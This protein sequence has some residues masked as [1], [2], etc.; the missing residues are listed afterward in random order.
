[1]KTHNL[2][3]NFYPYVRSSKHTSNVSMFIAVVA[4]GTVHLLY[5]DLYFIAPLRRIMD[6]IIL[7]MQKVSCVTRG[8]EFTLFFFAGFDPGLTV[9]RMCS[10]NG[11]HLFDRGSVLTSH[12][13]SS[14]CWAAWR[15]PPGRLHWAPQS[16]GSGCSVVGCRGGLQQVGREDQAGPECCCLAHCPLH[17]LPAAAGSPPASAPAPRKLRQS[18]KMT[19]TQHFEAAVWLKIQF[20]WSSHYLSCS[21]TAKSHLLS[22]VFFFFSCFLSN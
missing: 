1:M 15:V 7:T 13:P 8:S 21:Q 14:C 5:G 9:E 19:L 3:S 20:L 17:I 10:S 4:T 2:L 16:W 6:E 12:P 22:N 11:E 18:T